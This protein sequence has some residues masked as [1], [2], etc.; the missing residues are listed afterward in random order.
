MCI[1]LCKTSTIMYENL[2]IYHC[3]VP[4]KTCPNNTQNGTTLHCWTPWPLRFSEASHRQAGGQLTLG[5]VSVSMIWPKWVGTKKTK[6]Q[7]PNSPRMELLLFLVPFLSVN[8]DFLRLIPSQPTSSVASIK[9]YSC[10]LFRKKWINI[11]IWHT[12]KKI[13][14]HQLL[15]HI[16][17]YFIYIYI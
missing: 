10:A 7:T 16:I 11:C 1:Y 9:S 8:M 17:Q 12:C 6:L 14:L 2:S 4:I 5:P 15:T 13:N 3:L